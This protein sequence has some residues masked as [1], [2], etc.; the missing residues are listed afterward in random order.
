MTTAAAPNAAVAVLSAFELA[1]SVARDGGV[2]AARP[3]VA[4][5]LNAAVSAQSNQLGVAPP[6]SAASHRSRIVRPELK[7]RQVLGLYHRQS[8]W[9]RMWEEGESAS[10]AVECWQWSLP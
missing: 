10:R 7:L 4:D 1:R 3:L 6:L 5:K 9:E 2:S 8:G